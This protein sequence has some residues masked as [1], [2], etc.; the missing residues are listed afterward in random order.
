MKRTYALILVALISV[1]S[2]SAAP[3]SQL[4][5]GVFLGQPTGLSFGLDMAPAQ[6]LD[7]KDAWDFAGGQNGF[8]IILQGNWEM[9]FPG[10]FVIEGQDIVPFLG[11]GV[12]ANVSDAGVNI[13]VHLPFGLDYRFRKAPL[14]LFLELGLDIYL[15]PA[16]DFSASGGLG[17]RY[18]F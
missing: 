17:I 15:F 14:E 11:A 1:G 3:G 2:A 18:R 12:Q 4:G 8:A 9:G 13:G 16:T 6:W 5:A 10:T 7:F